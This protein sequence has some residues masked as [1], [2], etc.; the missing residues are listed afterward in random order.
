MRNFTEALYFVVLTAWIGGMWAIGYVVAPTLFATL[1]DRQMAGL[2]AGK[3]F[4]LMG[5]IGLGCG[6]YSLVFLLGRLGGGA[7]KRAAFWLV[8][9][10][11]AL[12]A[13]SQFGLQ[14]LMAQLKA[15]AWPREV[16]E[17]VLRDRFAAWHGISSI[18]YLVQSVL[19]V[20]L[21]VAASRGMK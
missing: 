5:W 3:L 2:V 19:G 15:E 1:G 8:F 16:M 4:A 9:V 11:L 13:V 10:I 7:L 18:L 12:T 17:T 14:P 20:W 6:A 21:V